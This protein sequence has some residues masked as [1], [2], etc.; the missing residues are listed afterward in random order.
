MQAYELIEF[1]DEDLFMPDIQATTKEGVLEELIQPLVKNHC[2][3]S[4]GVVL[5]ILKKRETLGS[6]GLGKG[7]AIPHCRTLAVTCLHIVGGISQKG[8]AFQA[9]DKKK[10]Y[11]FFLIVSPPQDTS[12][13][14]L[15]VL[16]K[17][18]EIVRDTKTRKALLKVRDYESFI[19]V[20]QGG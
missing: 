4:R 11:L 8:I 15:P 3:T 9:V 2:I 20:I 10:V 1:F 19:N 12:N 14:Y 7:I 16:G 5:E 13:A 18:V 17:I 6:T